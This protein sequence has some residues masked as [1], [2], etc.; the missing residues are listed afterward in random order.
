MNSSDIVNH[1]HTKIL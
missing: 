1:M